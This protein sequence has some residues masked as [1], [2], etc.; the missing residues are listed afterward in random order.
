L[1]SYDSVFQFFFKYKWS[2]FQRKPHE[3][4]PGWARGLVAACSGGPSM[5][6]LKRGQGFEPVGKR[7]PFPR[8]TSILLC[9]FYFA[10][11]C[12]SQPSATQNIAALLFDDSRMTIQTP[13]AKPPTL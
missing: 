4:L 8:R 5:Q 11:R 13:Q 2:L 1:L 9:F 7:L 3:M 12:T 10:L 6:P